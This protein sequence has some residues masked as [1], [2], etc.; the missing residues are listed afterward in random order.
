MESDGTWKA[1]LI[2]LDDS[3]PVH[4]P[5]VVYDPSS[6]M[7]NKEYDSLDKY[8]WHQLA[9]MLTRIMK[10]DN[11]GNYH[12]DPPKFD[13]DEIG[14]KLQRSYELGESPDLPDFGVPLCDCLPPS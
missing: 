12:K 7:Y 3:R 1:I 10:G 9:I 14:T 5:L 2:D 6:V 11:K 4:E 8:D 13:D